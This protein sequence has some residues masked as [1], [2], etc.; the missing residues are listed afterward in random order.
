[1]NDATTESAIESTAPTTR[2][3]GRYPRAADPGQWLE[4][5]TAIDNLIATDYTARGLSRRLHAAAHE[6]T[7]APLAMTA[8]LR[9]REQVGPGDPVVICSGWP[10]RS[11][12]MRGLTE[13]DGPVGAGYLARV[14]ETSLGC[15]PL[16]AVHPDLVAV[17]EVAL[18]SAGLIVTDIDTAIRG[19][20]GPHRAA[21]AAVLPLPADWDAAA[22]AAAETFDRLRPA[23]VICIEM[24]GANADRE[25]HNVTGRTVPS[26]LVGKADAFVLEATA[27]GVLTIG[28]GDGGNE[29]GMSFVADTVRELLADGPTIA[30]A[31][32]VD[33]LVVSVVSNYG[34]VGLAAAVA[35]ITDHADVL[36]VVD[37]A[38]ITERI[39][40]AGAIDGLTAY[41]DPKNDGLRPAVSAGFVELLATTVEMHLAGWTKG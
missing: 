10:S 8:A 34:A 25:F 11:W 35:A 15:V 18:R 13:T 1:M 27:R 9:L 28:I 32:P 23:G 30:P 5:G 40:D 4:L 37:L 6:R 2:S 7:G 26:E 14:L 41:V 17:A 39:S 3:D 12:L 16:F 21:T 29:L 33:L 22:T 36:R 20:H 19:K 24:P 31:T 38:R